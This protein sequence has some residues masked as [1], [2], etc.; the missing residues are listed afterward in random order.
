VKWRRGMSVMPAR[1]AWGG[2]V[3]QGRGRAYRAP[4][5]HT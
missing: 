4:N 5:K 1:L 2:G 3:G